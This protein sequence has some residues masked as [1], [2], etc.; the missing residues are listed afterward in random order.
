M[1]TYCIPKH[2][3]DEEILQIILAAPEISQ[4]VTQLITLTNEAGGSDNVTVLIGH[5]ESEVN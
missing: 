5:Q 2:I 1:T 3:S 4:A